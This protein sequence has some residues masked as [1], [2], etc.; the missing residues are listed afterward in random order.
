MNPVGRKP[1]S[2]EKSTPVIEMASRRIPE[3]SHVEWLPRIADSGYDPFRQLSEMTGL[4]GA[5][6]EIA[7]AA[8]IKADNLRT[9]C[10]ADSD[11]F[12]AFA[13]ESCIFG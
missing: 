6:P 9:G 11:P 1:S 12:V 2:P 3:N 4:P 7:R 10:Q 8:S 5:A 13:F